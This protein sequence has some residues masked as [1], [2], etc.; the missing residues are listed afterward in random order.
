MSASFPRK[1]TYMHKRIWLL[2]LFA[3]LVVAG[4]ANAQ[5][6]QIVLSNGLSGNNVVFS[7]TGSGATVSFVGTC[8]AS[9]VQGT[10]IFEPASG[11]P[12]IGSFQM[13]I[14]GSNPTL[15]G[16]TT[17]LSSYPV[18]MTGSTINFLFSMNG[19]ADT[20]QGTLSYVTIGN[21]EQQTPSLNGTFTTG[22]TTGST[23]GS[24]WNSG[25]TSA[26]VFTLNLGSNPKINSIVGIT[27]AQT[28][29]GPYSGDVP[30]PAPPPVPEPATIAMLGSG[31]L[32]IGGTLKRR[33]FK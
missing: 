16:T 32:V 13:S 26:A 20:L 6:T 15:A 17:G 8:G 4:T 33:F 5:V 25:T 22:S 2:A 24:L 30:A 31:L 18:S 3:T 19:G 1:E 29:G 28:N 27:G 14:T 10:A 23:L 12:I 7:G 9:C 21:A 11:T